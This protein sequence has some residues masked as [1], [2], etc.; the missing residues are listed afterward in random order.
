MKYIGILVAMD[1]EM[2]A[3]LN[4]MTDVKIKQIY[5]LNFITGKIHNKNC[6]LTMSGVG[7]VNAARTTQILIEKFDLKCVINVGAAGAVNYLLNIGDVVIAKHT[8]QHD[9]DI[10]AFGHSKGYITGVGQ[11]IPCDRELVSKF[12][13]IIENGDEIRNCSIR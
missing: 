10:T 13:K 5:D 8:V 12:Q 4:L 9:F 1:E 3:V 7:K 11:E 6:V 2:Q